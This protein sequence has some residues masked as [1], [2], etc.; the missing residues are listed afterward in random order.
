MRSAASPRR[1]RTI[2]VPL[3]QAKCLTLGHDWDRTICPGM[4]YCTRCGLTALCPGCI[5]V[6][7]STETRITYCPKHR[8]ALAA[9]LSKE[10][11]A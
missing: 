11:Q 10:V 2:R 1:T 4:F 7:P 9:P 3:T 6:L 5:P 8:R